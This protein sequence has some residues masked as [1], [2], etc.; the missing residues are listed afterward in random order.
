MLSWLGSML[1]SIGR[2]LRWSVIVRAINNIDERF[3]KGYAKGNPE[4]I[5]AYMAVAMRDFASTKLNENL[6]LSALT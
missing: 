5:G 3:G 2:W 6:S 1:G 4:L